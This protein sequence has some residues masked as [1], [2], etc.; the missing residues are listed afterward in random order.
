MGRLAV[1]ELAR[2]A[3]VDWETDVAVAVVDP[4]GFVDVAGALDAGDVDVDASVV[5]ALGVLNGGDVDGVVLVEAV[6][7]VP[8][9]PPFAKLHETSPV[10]ELVATSLSRTHRTSTSVPATGFTSTPMHKNVL[11]HMA[12]QVLALDTA[13]SLST[14][15]FATANSLPW[16]PE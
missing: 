4:I 14:F 9:L 2:V 1:G 6:E 12:A 11:S 15:W 5:V 16:S 3:R 13:L 8:A 7:V 10:G